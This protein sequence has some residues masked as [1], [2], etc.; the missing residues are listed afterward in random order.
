[1]PLLNSLKAI[2]KSLTGRALLTA[3]R[4]LLRGLKCNVKGLKG[5]VGKLA[6]VLFMFSVII[7]QIPGLQGPSK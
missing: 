3:L 4:A 5:P 1:M 2:I 7:M 6:V